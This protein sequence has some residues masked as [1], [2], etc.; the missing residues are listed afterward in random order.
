MHPDWVRSIR[1][2][3]ANAG[4]PFHFKQFGEF[5]PVGTAGNWRSSQD[6]PGVA[7]TWV[8]PDG[9]CG[10]GPKQHRMAKVGKHAAGRT[11]DGR[12]WDEFPTVD[13]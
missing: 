2:Q 4:V 6:V 1:D 5:A 7:H 12:I 10:Q 8:M 9:S 11:L 13:R 3:C